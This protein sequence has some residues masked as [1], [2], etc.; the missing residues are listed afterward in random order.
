[1]TT[2][3]DVE[4]ARI[5]S[6]KIQKTREGL[7]KSSHWSQYFKNLQFEKERIAEL[8]VQEYMRQRLERDKQ[9]ELERR[10]AKEEREK[11]YDKILQRQQKLLESKT[12]RNE[13]EYRRQR[14]E[15]EREFRRREKEA[16]IKK[17]EMAD[18]IA[19]AR[20]V[21]L[22]EV[23]SHNIYLLVME[24]CDFRLKY[25]IILFNGIFR[26]E[27]FYAKVLHQRSEKFSLVFKILSF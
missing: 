27:C 12:E 17:R 5:R 10:L 7:Q 24:I 14:E 3:E 1:M 21:Q 11:E 13:L 4:K 19:K 6:A 9:L 18:D 25:G 23:V 20:N 2:Q 8:K 15:V 26:F 22:E 16:A